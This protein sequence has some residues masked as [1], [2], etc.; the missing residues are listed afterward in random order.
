MLAA[1]SVA[2]AA[3]RSVYARERTEH[4]AAVQEAE[5]RLA[6]LLDRVLDSMAGM[7]GTAVHGT[8]V[9]VEELG[10]V[11]G[12]ESLGAAMDMCGLGNAG[13]CTGSLGGDAS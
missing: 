4:R 1:F 8:A 7:H 2:V 3:R 10:R 11:G 5:M 12:W 6:A 9:V 13:R